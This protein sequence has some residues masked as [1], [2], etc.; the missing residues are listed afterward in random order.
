MP[1]AVDTCARLG[2][3]AIAVLAI[4]G[5]ALFTFGCQ[6][7]P[8]APDGGGTHIKGLVMERIGRPLAGALIT[9]LDGPLAGR[10]TLTDASGKF[11]LTG[12]AAGVAMV[13]VSR[14][15]FLSRT[16]TLPWQPPG[17]TAGYALFWLD[18]IEPAIALDPGS[19][20]MTLAIDLATAKDHGGSPQAACGGFPGELAS[21]SYQVTIAEATAAN[22]AYNRV[23]RPEDP[24]LHWGFGLA[25]AARFVG[26]EWDDGLTEEFSGFRYLN[27]LGTAPTAAPAVAAGSSLS[28]PFYGSFWYCQSKAARAGYN[29]CSQVSVDQIV[30]QHM[31][32]SDHATMVF[33]K[34]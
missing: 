29:N 10:T 25:L 21:R 12:R 2:A 19:Y 1:R 5:S 4:G 33:T 6:H 13:R 32:E 18:T 15:G 28:I 30:E 14:D 16:E 11:E 7:S 23:V 8:T 17:S 9:L 24:T 3:V 34:R 27:I 20:T 22:P 31:C 26:F